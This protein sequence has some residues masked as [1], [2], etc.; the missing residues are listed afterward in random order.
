MSAR[1]R[2]VQGPADERPG[3]LAGTGH[4]VGVVYTSHY[5]TGTYRV[6]TAHADG[7]VSVLCL[8]GPDAGRVKT[9]RTALNPDGRRNVH[10]DDHPVSEPCVYR[11]E[12]RRRVDEAAQDM[13]AGTV[14][15][16]L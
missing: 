15:G 8:D 1:W 10:Q 16:Q 4:T 6:T 7:S 2:P 12:C 5:W 11:Y 9:H 13:A 3:A 14:S